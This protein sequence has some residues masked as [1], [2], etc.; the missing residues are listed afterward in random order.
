[1]CETASLRPVLPYS[2]YC[3][4]Y[5]I[6]GMVLAIRYCSNITSLQNSP[7]THW[8]YY[9]PP[10]GAPEVDMVSMALQLGGDP[11][12][13]PELLGGFVRPTSWQKFLFYLTDASSLGPEIMLKHYVPVM[14][15][16]LRYGAD[17][18]STVS[19]AG[20]EFTILKIVSGLISP[21]FPEE[22]TKILAILEE[23]LSL[24]RNGK[25]LR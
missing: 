5:I 19:E 20:K 9:H 3:K 25:R 8:Q 4:T 23:K 11:N 7:Y 24:S 18:R 22:S 15:V 16:L 2:A 6:S 17:P 1:M 14:E 10:C 21:N 13:K 12:W